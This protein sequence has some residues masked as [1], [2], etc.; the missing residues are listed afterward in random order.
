MALTRN[1]FDVQRA[2]RVVLDQNKI[3]DQLLAVGDV[4]TLAIDDMIRDA[5][6]RALR[7]VLLVAPGIMIDDAVNALDGQSIGGHIYGVISKTFT[8]GLAMAEPGGTVLDGVNVPDGVEGN[9]NFRI[10]AGTKVDLVSGLSQVLVTPDG[11]ACL[12]SAVIPAGTIVR[13]LGKGT[14]VTLSRECLILEEP[15]KSEDGSFVLENA[16]VKGF[17][18]SGTNGAEASIKS[19]IPGCFYASIKLPDNFLRLLC[20]KMSDWDY[21]VDH[22]TPRGDTTYYIQHSSVYSLRGNSQRPIVCVTPDGRHLEAF[23]STTPSPTLESFDY[24]AIP[25]IDTSNNTIPI[26]DKLYPSVIYYCASLV[27]TSLGD[28]NK[29]TAMERIAMQYVTVNTNTNREIQSE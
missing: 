5:I 23:G 12:I 25:E 7:A 11:S 13:E 9:P 27:C 14:L 8:T 16:P 15:E 21:A 2:V 3:T 24:V 26:S 20:L 18:Y 10:E 1:I 6:P 29:A 22:A 28:F 17:V 4:D 19:D